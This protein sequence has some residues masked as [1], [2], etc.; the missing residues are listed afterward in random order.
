MD[1]FR[2][3]LSP[4]PFPWQ[5]DYE[6][7][8]LSLGSCFAE[9]L[10]QRLAELKFPILNNPFGILYHPLVIAQALDRL[11]DGPPYPRDSLFVQQDLW[12]HFDFHSRYAH[13]DRDTALAVINEQLAQG[14]VFLS[15]TRLLILTLGTAWGYRLVSDDSLVANCHKLPAGKFRRYRST[16]T[17][18][19]EG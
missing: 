9:H 11:L 3:V 15:S 19:V 14:Q 12:R 2:T 7:P 18:I 4:P 10:S 6:T 8:V 13:P 17:E 1:H 5:L 16:T